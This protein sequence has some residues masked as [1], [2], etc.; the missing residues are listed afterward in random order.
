[1]VKNEMNGWSHASPNIPTLMTR[2][3]T[4]AAAEDDL[5]GHACCED[6]EVH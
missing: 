1:M 5:K 3:V 6:A 2:V 4:A